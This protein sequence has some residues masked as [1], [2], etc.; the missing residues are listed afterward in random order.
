MSNSETCNSSTAKLWQ[1][2]EQPVSRGHKP[3][4]AT[5]PSPCKDRASLRVGTV[6][7]ENRVLCICKIKLRFPAEEGKVPC[8][9]EHWEFSVLPLLQREGEESLGMTGLRKRKI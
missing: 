4:K 6:S 8:W 7:L 2:E 9:G 3:C 1:T 5:K